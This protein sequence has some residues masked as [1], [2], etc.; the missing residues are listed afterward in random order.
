MIEILTEQSNNVQFNLQM[1]GGSDYDVFLTIVSEGVDYRLK[2]TRGGDGLWSVTVP[3][4]L[5]LDVGQYNF[6]IDVIMDNHIY[7]AVQDQLTVKAQIKASATI[8]ESKPSAPAP[9][10]APKGRF[11]GPLPPAKRGQSPY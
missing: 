6:R 11:L 8:I 3:K 7:P 5:N 2:A 10:N 1:E 9:R 4:N